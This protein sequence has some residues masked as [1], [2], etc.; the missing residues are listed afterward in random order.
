MCLGDNFILVCEDLYEN[1]GNLVVI[2]FFGGFVW[3]ICY[4]F[5]YWFFCFYNNNYCLM[6]LDWV[7]S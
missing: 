1:V 4:I 6:I 7:M 2:I 3:Y 5:V